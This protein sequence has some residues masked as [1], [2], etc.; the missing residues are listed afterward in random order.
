[1][2]GIAAFFIVKRRRKLRALADPRS[3]T[4][5]TTKLAEME[6]QDESLVNR[7]WFLEGKWRSETAA[8]EK[9]HELD[10]RGVFVVPG[11]PVELECSNRRAH[12][13]AAVIMANVEDCVRTSD[14]R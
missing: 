5:T 8:E 14:L 6:D 1:L 4:T 13:D 3:P 2:V 11:S 12:E 9:Q 7:K 10:S